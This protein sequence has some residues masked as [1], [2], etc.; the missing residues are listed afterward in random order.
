MQKPTYL[1]WAF[2]YKIRNYEILFISLQLIYNIFFNKITI[3]L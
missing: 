3:K 2:F 1:G